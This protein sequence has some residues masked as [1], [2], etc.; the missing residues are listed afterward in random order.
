MV[1][2]HHARHTVEPEAVEMEL[3]KPVP[4]VAHKEPE[5]LMVPIVEQAAVPELVPSARALVE[6]EVVRTVEQ[7]ETV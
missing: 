1:V 4:Q 5:D 6:V 3:L 7:V 2:V